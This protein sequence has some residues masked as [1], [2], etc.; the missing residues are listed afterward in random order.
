MVY[1][2]L[3]CRVGFPPTVFWPNGSWIPREWRLSSPGAR[4]PQALFDNSILVPASIDQWKASEETREKALAVQLEN[5][6]KFHEAFPEG[7][8]VLVSL[9]MR[10]A[11]ESSSWVPSSSQTARNH[12][13]GR[14]Q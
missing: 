13:E 1:P 2:H 5:Q 8:A 4:Q 6:Q 12:A 9:A 3:D 11:T 7:L 14:M 10:K